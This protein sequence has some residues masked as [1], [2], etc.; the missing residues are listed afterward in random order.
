VSALA[1]FAG[2]GTVTFSLVPDARTSKILTMPSD[3]IGIGSTTL[4]GSVQGDFDGDWSK[5]RSRIALA[6]AAENPADVWGFNDFNDLLVMNADGSGRVRLT[7]HFGSVS[8][9]AWS[10]DGSKIAFAS[11]Q[12]GRSEIYVVNADGSH[13]VQLTTTGGFA[14]SWSPDGTRIAVGIKI[15]DV[16]QEP[17]AFVMDAA[18]GGNVVPL[19]PGEDPAW[20]PDG[21][22][23]ALATCPTVVCD[24]D[25][26]RLTLI[27]PDGSGAATLDAVTGAH[28]PAWAPD[29]SRIALRREM[30]E[31]LFGGIYTVNPDGSGIVHLL[32]PSGYLPSW[33]P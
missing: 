13:L 26:Y 12:S 22:V 19:M 11:D 31:N 14:P 8:G 4:P 7:S 15:T 25:G 16:L 17:S 21:S 29:G 20:S 1:V 24:P 2:P 3:A 18:D 5:D 33:G 27:H 6:N 23:I 32:S 10:P 30:P 9:P 28:E